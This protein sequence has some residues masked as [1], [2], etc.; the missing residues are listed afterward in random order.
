VQPSSPS[1]PL[2]ADAAEQ[3]FAAELDAV[4]AAG[5]AGR[6]PVPALPAS[7]LSAAI[8]DNDGAIL[9]RQERF[10]AVLGSDAALPIYVVLGKSGVGLSHQHS[11]DGK[12]ICLV[13]ARPEAATRWPIALSARQLSKAPAGARVVVAV[14]L[15]QHTE[16]LTAAAQAFGFTALETRVAIGLVQSGGLPEAAQ[17][18]AIA[19][20]TARE[21][22]A[23]ARR[24]AGVSR[25]PALVA[26]LT[27][28]AGQVGEDNR[29]ADRV[30][31]DT[32]GL[33][34]REAALALAL[35]RTGSRK[36]AARAAGVSDAIAKKHY[37]TIFEMLGA[38]SASDLS[39]TVLEAIAAALL[40]GAANQ[41]LPPPPH[42]R[43]PLRLIPRA[44]GGM[45]AISDYGPAK[46]R[47]LL[48]THSGSA[49]RLAPRSLVARLQA[50][51]WRPLA[52]DRPGFG[53]TSLRA[54][55][56]DPWLAACKDMDDALASLGLARVDI[57]VRGGVYA[58]AALGRLYPERLGRVVA[59]NPDVNTKESYKRTGAIGL[60]WRAGERDPKG[61]EAIV[62]WLAS[63]TTPHRLAALQRVLLR[64]SPID[65]AAIEDRREQD[66]L[67]RSV[68]LFAAGRLEGA[69]REHH[70]HSRGVECLALDDGANWRVIMGAHDPMH[71]AADMERFWRVRLPGARFS[72]IADGG[73]FLHLTHADAVVSALEENP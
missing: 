15:A 39:R 5:E 44:D 22:I 13:V 59:I 52:I 73:R 68:G 64:R 31:V 58:V 28:V 41:E 54:D 6:V 35:M 32:F 60:L 61:Y 38:K 62:R 50:R 47:P 66:D 30:L 53:M 65:L 63:H 71:A 10:A 45:I 67:R 55:E 70:E 25:Q 17:R 11:A 19:Y 29:E 20:D 46:G 14:A 27:A 42:V 26:R 9:W 16:H 23:S 3:Q 8:V 7:A 1:G 4:V 33:T 56:A 49:T 18:C 36:E 40:L 37:A 21:A 72:T 57:L 2:I 34:P 69:I 24:K 51:G 12:A 48:I 43:E